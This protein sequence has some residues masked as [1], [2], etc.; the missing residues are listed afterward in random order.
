MFGMMKNSLFGNTEETEYKLLSSEIKDGVSFEVRRYDGAKYAVVSSEGRTFD[1]VTGELVRKLLMYIGGS[2]EQAVAMGTAAPIIV[3]VYPRNDGVLS[4]R[5]VVAIR[6]PTS[7]QQEAP[8]PSDTAIT[9]E[10]RPGMTVY[11][12]RQFGGFAAES[13]Y[14]AEALRL[15]R[16]LGETAPFQRK[17]YFCCSYDPPLKP[18]GRRN[19]VWF[20]QEEP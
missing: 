6:I 19:E 9:V 20:L 7:Y 1:Q 2:N 4:R 5:L 12:L 10:D 16:T 15:T 18:Y 3:T 14:R 8:T 11:A 17:Q 13:E